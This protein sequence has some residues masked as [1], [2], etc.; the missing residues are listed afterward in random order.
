MFRRTGMS[1]HPFLLAPPFE[2]RRVLEPP[3]LL[4]A[5]VIPGE[6]IDFLIKDPQFK[7]Y[8]TDTSALQDLALGDGT[9][10][11]GVLTAEPTGQAFITSGKPIKE[12]GGPIFFEYLAAAF[13]KKAGKDP[14]SFV[15]KVSEVIQQMHSDGTLQKLSQQ[16]YSTDLATA[17]AKFDVNTLAQFP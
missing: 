6:K 15:K 3:I 12:L 4:Q 7:G 5:V 11:D 16:Y 10:L 2:I 1:L 17:A 8:D 13:D 14:T 9:R